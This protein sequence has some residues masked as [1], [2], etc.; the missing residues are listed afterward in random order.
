MSMRV[1]TFVTHLRPED[2]TTL[3][4]FLGQLHDVLMRNYGDEIMAMLQE[5]STRK[6]G[7]GEANDEAF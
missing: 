3:I 1:N 2:A 7:T 4:E 5:A 6:S